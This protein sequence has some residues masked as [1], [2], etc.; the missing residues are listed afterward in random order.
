MI[1]KVIKVGTSVA[2]VVPKNIT[3]Q[4]DMFVGSEVDMTYDKKTGAV[5]FTPVRERVTHRANHIA[6]LTMNF[7][8]RYRDD[9]EKLSG[10]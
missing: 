9:L 1:Q 4:N 5:T 2:V 7:I 10:E 3:I 8:D 6:K